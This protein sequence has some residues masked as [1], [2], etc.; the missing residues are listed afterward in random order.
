MAYTDIHNIAQPKIDAYV[1]RTKRTDHTTL[2]RSAVEWASVTLEH[3]N[4]G[5]GWTYHDGMS[6]WHPITLEEFEN[7]RSRC[8]VLGFSI[9]SKQ[10][11]SQALEVS[12]RMKL[13]QEWVD[14]G[15][16]V[17]KIDAWSFE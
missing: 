2:T 13:R 10:T 7:R 17:P 12:R 6:V 9:P 16:R 8:S 4:F 3:I 1:E 5:D 14:M 11:E 15:L